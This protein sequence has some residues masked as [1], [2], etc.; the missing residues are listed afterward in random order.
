[1]SIR[2]RSLKMEKLA[3][4]YDAE[5]LPVWSERFGRM[6]LRGLQ[7]PEKGQILDVACGTVSSP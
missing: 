1:M 3:R 2:K 7:F 6:L 5:I 4:I